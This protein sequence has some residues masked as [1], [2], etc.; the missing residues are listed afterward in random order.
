MSSLQEL[1]SLVKRLEAVAIKLE[2]SSGSSPSIV[3]AISNIRKATTSK[4]VDLKTLKDVMNS[5]ENIQDSGTG[6]SGGPNSASVDEFNEI[7][8]SHFK[9]Y[10]NISNKIGGDVAKHAS[11]VSE[12]IDA[13]MAF[14]ALAS[15]S[16][17]PTSDTTN[18]E[19]LKPTSDKISNVI[20]F[21]EANRRSEFFNHL[22]AISESIPALGWVAV[23]PAPSPFVKEMNDAGQF[24]TNRV[25]KDFKAKAPIHVDWVKSWIAF[26]MELQS[27]VKK[28]HTTGLVW[29]P[30]G[31]EAKS[32]CPPPPP[33]GGP[34]LPPPPPPPGLFDD[35]APNKDDSNS[36]RNDLLDELNKGSDI[37]KGLK[38]VTSDMQT[39]K[40]PSLRGSLAVQEKK[41][42]STSN[43]S[44]TAPAKV[45]KAPKFELDGKKWVVEFQKDNAGL[46]VRDTEVN[47]SIYAYKCEGCVLRVNG[48]INNII[49]DSCKKTSVVFDSLVS[50]CEFVNCQSIKMQVMGKVPTISIDKSD[51]CQMYLSEESYDVVIVSSKSSEMNVLISN[52]EDY[53][54]Y[55]IAEQFKTTFAGQKLQTMPT[56]SV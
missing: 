53:V 4:N 32:A 25:L 2:G 41:S 37:T 34:P 42:A 38:K 17:K 51:G 8:S 7:V 54:E 13:Q 29:N 36:S 14:L 19:L 21:R 1:E 49:L 23:A 26:L 27:F 55:P 18:A 28:N 31:G 46:I 6:S 11:M 56:E 50:S 35:V 48:K 12:A 10:Y 43:K 45:N 47:Q 3:A 5:L 22:S 33:S 40:N 20:S 39:H 30:K 9:N 24:Y 44:F 52:G 15:I 16:K